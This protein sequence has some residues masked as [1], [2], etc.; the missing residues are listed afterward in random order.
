[1]WDWRDEQMAFFVA[2]TLVSE[3]AVQGQ[4]EIV[5]ALPHELKHELRGLLTRILVEDMRAYPTIPQEDTGTR[6]K[7]LRGHDPTGS[8]CR[9]RL[10]E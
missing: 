2:P 8:Q 1:M 10:F 6:V 7:C 4:G 9:T 5:S 3:L